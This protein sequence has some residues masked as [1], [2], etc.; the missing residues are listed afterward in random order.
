MEDQIPEHSVRTQ[1]SGLQSEGIMRLA[2]DVISDIQG[3]TADLV[4]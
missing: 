2:C 4:A 3:I 1:P